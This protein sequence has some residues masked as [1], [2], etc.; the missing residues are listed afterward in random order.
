[1]MPVPKFSLFFLSICLVVARHRYPKGVPFMQ[2]HILVS[3]VASMSR[4]L[5]SFLI[6]L[7]FIFYSAVLILEEDDEEVDEMMYACQVRMW[8]D[9]MLPWGIG[10]CRDA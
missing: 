4:R 1:M 6:S 2:S 7:S 10:H 8:T 5:F 3:V 9:L